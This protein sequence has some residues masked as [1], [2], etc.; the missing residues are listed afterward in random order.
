MTI[1]RIEKAYRLWWNLNHALEKFCLAL[2]YL[3]EGDLEA[4]HLQLAAGDW[5]CRREG[6]SDMWDARWE[7]ER[8]AERANLAAAKPG[9][10][11]SQQMALFQ[12]AS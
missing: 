1:D 2:E 10:V 8:E 5:P 12:E 3:Y 11:G 4:C 6:V 9:S 7:R